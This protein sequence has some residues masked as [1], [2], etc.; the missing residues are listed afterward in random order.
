LGCDRRARLLRAAPPP[1]H[2]RAVVWI[3]CPRAEPPADLATLLHQIW[4]VAAATGTGSGQDRARLRTR[5]SPGQLDQGPK[6]VVPPASL[7]PPCTLTREACRWSSS[8]PHRSWR[9]RHRWGPRR[10]RIQHAPP[11][12]GLTEW[13]RRRGCDGPGERERAGGNV[14]HLL[15]P[16]ERR[17]ATGRAWPSPGGA[18]APRSL[19]RESGVGERGRES[20]EPGR[21]ERESGVG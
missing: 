18:R 2:S 7:S 14:G 3:W 6:G 1:P 11:P 17:P 15:P 16:C 21:S 5:P 9:A 4:G 13:S 19:E 8:P 10:Y 12:P 20:A